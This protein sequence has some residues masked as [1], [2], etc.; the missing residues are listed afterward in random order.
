M[1]KLK[2]ALTLLL[3]LSLVVLLSTAALA[4]DATSGTCGDN[5]TWTLD[6]DTGVLTISGTGGMYIY[7]GDETPS[8]YAFTDSIKSVV[9]ESG[10]TSISRWAFNNC[11]NLT[12]ISMP[13]SITSIGEGAFN[14]CVSLSNV[15]IPA[16]VTII[17]YRTFYQCSGLLN[18]II[19]ES[20]T[21]IDER[22]FEG[23]SSLT[24]ITIPDSVTSIGDST[25]RK[26]S[27][28][29]SVTI[30][31]SVTSIG[32]S[33]FRDCSSLTDVYYSGD[34]TDWDAIEIGSSNECLTSAT[35]HYTGS[36]GLIQLAA[37][38]DLEWGVD[39]NRDGTIDAYV[40][41]MI[42][43]TL[44]APTQNVYEVYLYQVGNDDHFIGGA[45]HYLS[46]TT[47]Y[48]KYSETTFLD[49]V[50]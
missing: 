21:S 5:L 32:S 26:C 7:E 17:E 38:S 35:I 29:T 10:A 25:F 22:A 4:D 16:G 8:W 34:E 44:N 15:E 37:P 40:P 9:I 48:T 49:R 36:D 27:S 39:Y 42:S 28:L 11:R 1:R 2:A 33:A 12:S 24:S 43:W 19:P 30:P 13:D 47:E 46:S 3:T 23:C 14:Y 6:T 31:S 41:G 50:Y 18:V 45:T 20:V